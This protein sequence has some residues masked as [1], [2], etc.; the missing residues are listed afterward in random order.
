MIAFSSPVFFFV[1]LFSP[2]FPILTCQHTIAEK[3]DI[4]DQSHVEHPLQSGAPFKVPEL[5]Q[6]EYQL[7]YTK[8]VSIYVGYNILP[9]K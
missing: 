3:D 8:F 2:L 5:P 4:G 7:N 1:L 9:I 6:K